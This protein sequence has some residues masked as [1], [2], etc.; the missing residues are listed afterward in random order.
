[1][2]KLG[3]RGVLTF[4]TASGADGFGNVL[5]VD[6]HPMFRDVLAEALGR[7]YPSA[8]IWTAGCFE[9]AMAVA[10]ER[11]PIDLFVLDL[12]IGGA[13]GGTWITRFRGAFPYASIVIVTMWEDQSVASQMIQAGADGFLG[14]S[15]SAKAMLENLERIRAGEFVIS[16]SPLNR[17][18]VPLS[19]GEAFR[20]TPRQIEILM[21]LQKQMQNKAIARI[22]DLSPNTVRNHIVVLMR[23][24]GVSKRRLIVDRAIELGLIAPS[25]EEKN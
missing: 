23:L 18:G 17:S 19:S 25:I 6:D 22:L 3:R 4:Q 24:L 15:L 20:L 14:K 5:I 2:L 16:I 12:L 13:E 9:D 7:T 21:C 10:R 11:G 1:M 8:S